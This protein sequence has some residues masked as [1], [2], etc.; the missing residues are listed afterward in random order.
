MVKNPKYDNDLVILGYLNQRLNETEKTVNSNNKE[1]LSKIPKNYSSPPI[2]PYYKDS[3]LCYNNKIYRCIAS[4]LQGVFSWDDWSVVA[5]DDTTI[6]DFI[7]NTYEVEKL[8]IQEQIDGKVQT[9]YQEIDPALEW[10]TDL[11]KFKHTGDYWYNTANNTQWRYNQITTT[12]PI[13][14]GW[15][16]VNVPNAVFDLIDKKKSIYTEKPTSYKK[17]DLWVIED[18]VLDE[19][20]PIGTTEN[21]IARGDWV[22]S[23]T[24]SNVY[25]KEHWIKRDE[26]VDI[27]YLETHY[28]NTEVLDTKFTV[29]E[30]NVDSKITKAKD[31]IELQVNQNYTTKKETETIVYDYDEKIGKINN[32]LTT[33]GENI[34]NL[35]VENGKISASVTNV[36]TIVNET[37]VNL[38]NNYMPTEQIN[39]QNDSLKK[40]LE[41]TTTKM[42]ELSTTIDGVNITVKTLGATIS[43]MNY[44]F[45]TDAL[46]ISTYESKIN[47]K[48]DNMGV[49]VYNYEKLMAIFN[50]K[51]TGVGDLIVTGTAQIG[52]LKFMKS[53]K[54]SK[55]ITAIH[56][57]IS[58]IQTLEDLESG[59]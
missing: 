21:P 35:S 17:D 30:S 3:L 46:T 24:D 52:Y 53:T 49:K 19:D 2:T 42:T 44:A 16:Q 58:E 29:L 55:P 11:E 5:T 48:F 20:L 37:A 22:F 6:S 38:N 43:D 27:T 45:K 32:T 57:I 23:I 4:R 39:A 9:Y 18:T 40:E 14:Y 56:H 28:Y 34:S 1:E 47:S 26:K 7:N 8:E 25:N 12:S 54:N 31:E 51:G 41:Y 15:G 13:T 50:H 59:E 36:E 10:K 33:Y